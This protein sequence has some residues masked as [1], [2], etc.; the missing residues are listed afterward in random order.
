MNLNTPEGRLAAA[1]SLGPDGYN[2]AMKAHIEN[3]FV[4]VVNGY[5][6]RWV[7]SPF[8][9]LCAIH[10][11][12]RAFLKIEDSRAYANELPKGDCTTA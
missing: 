4:E 11:T 9:R 3:S 6:L 12:D 10:G 2:R 5:G 1:E 7:G 8:G